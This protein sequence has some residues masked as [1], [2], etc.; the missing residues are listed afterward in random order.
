[1]VYLAARKAPLPYYIPEATISIAST[2]ACP[3]ELETSLPKPSFAAP[4]AVPT[5]DASSVV[6]AE[7][8]SEGSAVTRTSMSV[9]RSASASSGAAVQRTSTTAGVESSGTV[10]PVRAT[11]TGGAG[12]V[13][14]VLWAGVL[15]GGVVVV[16]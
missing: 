11:A 6:G 4:S 7:S 15:V 16:V 9:S 12:R 2:P 8:S 1:M 10:A 5:S 13:G 14:V 3:L